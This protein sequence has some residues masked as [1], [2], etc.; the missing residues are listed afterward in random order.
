MVFN[1]QEII[2]KYK[3]GIKPDDLVFNF[4][5]GYETPDKI[6]GKEKWVV[7]RIIGGMKNIAERI[8]KLY[9]DYEPLYLC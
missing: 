6:K 7:K 8:Q 5:E 9:K 1:R 2:N 4:L 3:T